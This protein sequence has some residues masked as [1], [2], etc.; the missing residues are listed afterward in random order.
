MDL[1]LVNF[2]KLT[3]VFCEDS[4]FNDEGVDTYEE[5]F[6]YGTETFTSECTKGMR[7]SR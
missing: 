7:T 3:R 1:H 5:G 4:Q 2:R 6:V